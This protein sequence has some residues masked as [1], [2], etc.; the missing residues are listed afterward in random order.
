MAKKAPNPDEAT[1]KDTREPTSPPDNSRHDW[2]DKE[3]VDNSFLTPVRVSYVDFSE[4]M[5]D[6]EE[7]TYKSFKGQ[8]LLDDG[9]A[10]RR[11]LFDSS[12][13]SPARL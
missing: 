4:S 12:L 8:P 7:M 6:D 9:G 2:K 13:S 3:N 5:I 1:P 10:P 11:R